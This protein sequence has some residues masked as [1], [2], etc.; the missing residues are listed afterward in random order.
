MTDANNRRVLILTES[1]TASEG[2]AK[3][4]KHL[5]YTSYVCEDVKKL[6]QEIGH[7]VGAVFL[8][9][10]VLM[11]ETA[12]ALRRGLSREPVWS[13]IPVMMQ[14]QDARPRELS[15]A[16]DDL[17]HVVRLSAEFQQEAFGT[18]VRSL[19][20]LRSRQYDVGRLHA[21]LEIF[22]RTRT[23]FFMNISHEV[24]TPLCAILGFSELVMKKTATEREQ[25]TYL[26]I[27]RRNAQALSSLFDNIL[28][29]TRME[30]GGIELHPLECRIGDLL[31]D[32]VA[33]MGKEAS[34]KGLA[35][36]VQ[37]LDDFGDTIR[38]DLPRLQQ[39]LLYVV[40]NAIKFTSHGSVMIRVLGQRHSET[41][42]LEIE[43]TGIGISKEHSHRLFKAFS[44][45][46][47][48]S[49]RPYGGAG[50]GLVLARKLARALGGDLELKWSVPG[51]GSCFALS[52]HVPMRV[53]QLASMG[54]R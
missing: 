14:T 35:L 1:L 41:L 31:G 33:S 4:F 34:K 30:S 7:G 29:L 53:D 50:L 37:R 10:R 26:T 49:T 22:R 23:E 25:D 39:I 52:V 28:D 51:G 16:L 11:P 38:I 17:A 6:V 32:V 2:F 15:H 45:V 24:R 5:G 18:F 12:D 36:S 21:Q 46:D 9:D 27:I 13:K 42:R 48:S 3:I 47:G 54:V 44:Q 19:L 8:A 43:D 20:E 40:A